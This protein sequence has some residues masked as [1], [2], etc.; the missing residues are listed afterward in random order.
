M[1]RAPHRAGRLVLVY[2][3]IAKDT[4]EEKI[5]LLQSKKRS[6]VE[7]AL[8]GAGGAAGI[9]REDLLALL[10]REMTSPHVRWIYDRIVT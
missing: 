1:D 2:R 6:L 10:A 5:A 3:L 8:E 9:T 4:V 7:A